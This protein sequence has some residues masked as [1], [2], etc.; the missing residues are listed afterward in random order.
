VVVVKF[1]LLT[2]WRLGEAL[3]LRWS[4]IDLPRRTVH[5]ADSKSGPSMRPLSLA[6]CDLLK[7][8]NR[9]G[10]LV[11]PATKGTGQMTGFSTIWKRRISNMGDLP[12]DISPHVFRHSFSSLAADL[13][14]SEPTIAAMIGHKGQ[15]ITS[16]YIHT[17][18]AIL[19]A[20]A[21]TVANR[22]LELMGEGQTSAAI[23]PFRA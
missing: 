14:Y 8:M 19:L 6:A 7:G 9:S 20:A 5:L 2:G 18:D 1:L 21:D 17:A 3:A 10:D 12:A 22:T 16:R 13:G 4:E 11:F 15:T 23:I